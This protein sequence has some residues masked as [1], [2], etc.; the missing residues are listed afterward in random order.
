MLPKPEGYSFVLWA[1]VVSA[2]FIAFGRNRAL[3]RIV[4]FVALATVAGAVIWWVISV[5]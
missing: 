1:L 3:S 4:L 2:V 5:L